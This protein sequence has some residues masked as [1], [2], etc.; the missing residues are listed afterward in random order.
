MANEY[1]VGRGPSIEQMFS[2]ARHVRA[3]VPNLIALSSPGS[4][5]SLEEAVSDPVNAFTVHIDRGS[6]DAKWRQVRQGYDFK[7]VKCW[8]SGNEPPGPA[9]SVAT[10]DNPLQLAMMRAVGVM[11]GGSAYVLHTGTGVFGNGVPHPSAG[12][13]PPNFWEIPNFDA[14]CSALR[15]IDP[16]L[17]EGVENW[18]V[19]NTQWRPP[20]PVAPFQPHEH[21]EGL[22]GSGVN[23]AYSALCDDG[24]VIQMPCGVLHHAEMTASYNLAE[25]TVYDP[26][27]LQPWSGCVNRSFRQGEKMDL[28]GAADSMVAYIIHGRR[29]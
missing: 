11:C 27:S 22:R 9:S 15:N 29:T 13:R 6:S 8:V 14:I 16:L 2:M 18:R 21:W 4:W 3:R 26:L 23:K 10:N 19:A 1:D 12:P 7:N 25:V 24:R 17:P 5:E 20:N 28:P